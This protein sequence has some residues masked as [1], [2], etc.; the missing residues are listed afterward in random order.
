[1]AGTRGGS[2]REISGSQVFRSKLRAPSAQRLLRRAALIDQLDACA[3]M[4]LSLIIGPA[5]TGKTSLAASW[6]ATTQT[7]TAWLSLD[8]GDHDGTHFWTGVIAALEDLT[9]D[10][11]GRALTLLQRPG[12]IDDAV[13]V[14]LNDLETA[15]G[16]PSTLVIDNIHL[17]DDN[18]QAVASLA[19][20]V[21][22]LPRW[23]HVILLARRPPRLPLVRM[24][25]RGELGE[26]GFADLM[27]SDDEAAALLSALAP[28]LDDNT[29]RAVVSRADG[30]AA[31]IQLAALSAR[32]R[33]SRTSPPPDEMENLLVSDYVWQEV[34]AAER[35]EL[36]D[37]LL[38]IA[39]ADRVNPDLATYLCGVPNARALLS[40]A[41]F[42]GLFVN[43]LG[44]GDW[45]EIHT[46]VR[47][48]LRAELLRRSPS[49]A[50]EM[51][52]RAARWFEE[53]GEVGLALDQWI[54]AQEPREALRLLAAKVT[55]LY[56]SGREATIVRTIARLPA[57]IARGDLEAAIEL[58]WSNLLVSSRIFLQAVERVST[59][60]R[61]I[62]DLSPMVRARLTMLQS[63]A[64]TVQGDWSQG[65]D[66]ARR[67]MS[68]Q[69]EDW[70]SDLLGRFCW[71][72]IARGIALSEGWEASEQ[73]RSLTHE[74][75][76]DP[77]RR[78][79]FEGTRALAESLTGHPVDALRIAAGV[80]DAA[81]VTNMSILRLELAAAEA[82]AHRELG[83]RTRAQSELIALGA[84][85]SGPV[86]YACLLADLELAQS[87]LDEGDVDKA[88]A[89]FTRAAEL[90]ESDIAGPDARSWLGRVGDAGCAGQG[91]RRSRTSLVGH[92]R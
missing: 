42:R 75:S 86:G 63:I 62:P 45:Y 81:T 16:P 48:R 35:P 14:L 77:E 9:H 79:A 92:H 91:R 30:W 90:V 78:L 47:E 23:L 72:M 46:L 60:A 25:A 56:D 89:A 18:D 24:R 33:R 11:L 71:N 12:S 82:I 32:S 37:A 41:E 43:R 29:V 88:E 3:V 52:A 19:V 64:A 26:I 13:V 1:M 10:D 65:G 69:G 5:G 51:H 21:Q 87:H 44:S 31:G 74:V 36:V 67:A 40:E 68:E 80:R 34:F 20:F 54:L 76:R 70:S 84:L 22:H 6:V 2:W 39:V 17:L 66:L 73:I 50:A 59:W 15:E 27:L 83:D 53:A 61:H 8:D 85:S 49:R 58:A 7:P 57:T 4:P 55:A 38:D 28:S